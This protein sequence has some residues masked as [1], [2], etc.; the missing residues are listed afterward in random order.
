[1]EKEVGRKIAC[2]KS[3]KVPEIQFLNQIPILIRKNQIL[4]L[5]GFFDFMSTVF[6]N[7]FCLLCYALH[8]KPKIILN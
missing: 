3:W 6:L 1:M 4:K 7:C 8:N 5:K 2:L